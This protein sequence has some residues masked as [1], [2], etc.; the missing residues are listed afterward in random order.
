MIPTHW[1]F[2]NLQTGPMRAIK[3]LHIEREAF[4][5]RF[6]KSVTKGDEEN[7]VVGG[8]GL[9]FWRASVGLVIR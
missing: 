2:A 7:V 3:Q 4:D 9:S 8:T 5:L 6:F 1:N